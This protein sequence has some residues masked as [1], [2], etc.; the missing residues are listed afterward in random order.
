MLQI[1]NLKRDDIEEDIVRN[2]SHHELSTMPQSKLT[3]P[4]LL[5]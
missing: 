5:L 3:E 2:S 4:H 1:K